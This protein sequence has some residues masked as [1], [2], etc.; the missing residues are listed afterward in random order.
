MRLFMALKEQTILT[1]SIRTQGTSADDD[2]DDDDDE[3]EEERDWKR[4]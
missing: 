1:V 3:E 4:L 2:E